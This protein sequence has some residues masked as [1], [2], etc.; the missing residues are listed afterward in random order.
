MADA[1]ITAQALDVILKLEAEQLATALST[2]FALSIPPI[3]RPYPTELPQLDLHTERLDTVFELA[4]GSLLHLEYQS[5]HRSDT[6]LRFLSYDV[7][8]YRQHQRPIRTVVVY[9][10]AVTTAPAELD[11]IALRYQTT[12]IFLGR[13]DGDEAY[14]RLSERVARGETLNE[15][16]RLDLVFL[17][18]M[19]HRRSFSEVVATALALARALPEAQQ[20][21]AIGAL[22]GLA[23]H[24]VG[25][26][27]L[28]RLMEDLMGTSVL[29]TVLADSMEQGMVR[30]KRDDLLKVLRSRFGP[31]ADPLAERVGALTDL[32]HLDAVFDLALS[33]PALDD[34]TQAL[35]APL[36]TS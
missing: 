31:L 23:Y 9:G 13:R 27:S 30:A 5:K 1:R 21:R 36:P 11:I 14:Q 15:N 4:D 19:A 3:V 32:D 8:L 6:L 35:D 29:V 22:L 10:P 12:N 16:E 17:P 20:R 2:Y 34:V 33:A 24:Y 7:A 25:Q 28:D 26:E 18:L